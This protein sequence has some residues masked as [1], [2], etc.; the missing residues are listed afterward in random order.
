MIT[1]KRGEFLTWDFSCI[2]PLVPSNINRDAL[3]DAETNK[4]AKYSPS[5]PANYTFLP[6]IATTLTLFGSHALAFFKELGKRISTRTEDP[7]EG[8]YLRQRL[9][10]NITKS[11]YLS[12]IFS[13]TDT[14]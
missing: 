2:D 11:N 14:P 7:N 9:A 4:L 6:L 5:L 1:W 13:M 12:F 10:L 3:V 8:Y